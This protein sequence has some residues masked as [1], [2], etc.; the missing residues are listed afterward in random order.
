M[1]RY[2]DYRDGYNS[3]AEFEAASNFD[4]AAFY[5]EQF[6]VCTGLVLPAIR[7]RFKAGDESISI[8]SSLTLMSNGI[9]VGHDQNYE[10]SAGDLITFSSGARYTQ[11]ISSRKEIH[12]DMMY[13]R[14]WGMSRP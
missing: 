4:R 7:E 2:G 9:L 12:S 1:K 5:L 13:L 14:G 11:T 6:D 10:E 3:R 8:T